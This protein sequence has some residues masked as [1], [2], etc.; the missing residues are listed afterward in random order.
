MTRFA[1]LL[2]RTRNAF[3]AIAATSA[4]AT[5]GMMASLAPISADAAVS[6]NTT[7]RNSRCTAIV[8]AAG[9]GAKIKLYNGARPSGV[10][11]IGGGNTLLASGA[12]GATIGTCASGVLDWD[13]AGFTQTSSGFTAGTPTF[14]DITT[15]A[16][17]IV[18]RV[19]IGSGAGYWTFTG[20]VAT[21]QN[22]TLTTL[23]FTEGN[24]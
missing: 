3:L 17:V 11:A 12:F 23:S 4:L 24:L 16:D 14:A 19:D 6:F 13:E 9:S 21:G 18:A 22:I 15:S 1:N 10:A 2:S 7:L 8:T 5:A 20:S